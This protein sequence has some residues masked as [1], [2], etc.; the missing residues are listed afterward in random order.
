MKAANPAEAKG[1]GCK[2]GPIRMEVW[3]KP[4][5]VGCR[6]G[7]RV[8]RLDSEGSGQPEQVQRRHAHQAEWMLGQPIR[9]VDGNRRLDQSE[10]TGAESRVVGSG[11]DPT[12]GL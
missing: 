11:F 10:A 2:H 5:T 12:S 6:E 3:K 1:E 9:L 8:G 7:R 4:I